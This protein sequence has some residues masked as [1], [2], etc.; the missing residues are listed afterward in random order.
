MQFD[1]LVDTYLEEFNPEVKRLGF[2]VN[3]SNNGPSRK[4]VTPDGFKGDIGRPN[5]E[6]IDGDLF[7]Q[8]KNVKRKVK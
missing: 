5:P 6:F 2:G 4:G 7:P 3:V 1:E 8:K